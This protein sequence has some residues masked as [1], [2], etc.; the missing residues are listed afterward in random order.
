MEWLSKF[1]LFTLMGWKIV[2]DFPKELKK[3]IIIVAPHT[4]WVDF[5]VGVATRFIKKVP[6]NFIGKHTLF[7]PPFG[8]IFRK[9]GGTPVDRSKSESRVE[10][11]IKLFNEKEQFILAISPE[12]TRQKIDHWK[13]GFYYVAKG[14]QIPIVMAGL[15]FDKKFVEISKPYYLCGDIQK[16]FDYFHDFFKDFQ[17]KHADQFEPNFNQNIKKTD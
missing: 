1:Y 2:G 7:N 16:D 6:A 11:L 17:G 14:A 9:L 15:N 13:T 3:Y 12:G 10:A 4:S 8:F 5:P